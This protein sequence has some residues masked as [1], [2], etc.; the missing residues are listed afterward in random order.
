ML[1]MTIFIIHYLSQ[2][3]YSWVLGGSQEGKKKKICL[4]MQE[5]CIPS[6]CQEYPLRKEMAAHFRILFFLN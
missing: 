5:M 3:R 2:M 4:P 6:L 1:Y